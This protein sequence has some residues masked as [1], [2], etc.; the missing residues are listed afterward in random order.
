[1]AVPVRDVTYKGELKE[2]EDGSTILLS[3]ILLF[4]ITSRMRGR[5]GGEK[6]VLSKAMTIIFV[7]KKIN[8]LTAI[9]FL[10]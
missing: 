6:M 2:K 8:H 3:Y 9:S 10:K 1:M 7:L 4:V 5:E